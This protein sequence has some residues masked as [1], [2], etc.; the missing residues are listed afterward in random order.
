MSRA[1]E[2]QRMISILNNDDNPSF[3]VRPSKSYKVRQEPTAYS[4]QPQSWSGSG[5]D[6]P[7]SASLRQ[8]DTRLHWRDMESSPESHLYSHKTPSYY[9]SSPPHHG[10]PQHPSRGYEQAERR[11]AA[12]SIQSD[13]RVREQ[14]KLSPQSSF[15]NSA[16]CTAP[17]MAKKNKHACP[18]ATS[19]GCTAT[20]TTSGH[21]ARHG[22]KHTGEK[23][24]HCPVC[25][26]AFTRKDNMKQHRRTHRE[27]G[28]DTDIDS[29]DQSLPDASYSGSPG[30]TTA[31][32]SGYDMDAPMDPRYTQSRRHS[33]RSVTSYE[34]SPRYAYTELPDPLDQDYERRPRSSAY[35]SDTAGRFL[36]FLY[37]TATAQPYVTGGDIYKSLL[38]ASRD[39]LTSVVLYPIISLSFAQLWLPTTT[40]TIRTTG[41]RRDTTT[42]LTRG[43]NCTKKTFATAIRLTIINPDRLR[44]TRMVNR[45]Q[46]EANAQDQGGPIQPK[47]EAD[48]VDGIDMANMIPLEMTSRATV[49]NIAALEA[50]GF[51]AGADE[52]RKHDDRSHRRRHEYEYDDDPRDRRDYDRRRYDYDDRRRD[53]SRG[54]HRRHR[55]T[56][57][58]SRSRNYKDPSNKSLQNTITAALTAG[59]LEAYRA[60]NEPGEW[61]GE[62]GKR[63]LAAVASAGGTEKLLDHGGSGK[64]S[65][66]HI[67]E[68][69]LAGLASGHLAGKS[70]SGRHRSH[71]EGRSKVSTGAT[72]ALLAAAGKKAYEHYQAKSRD[73]GRGG[74]SSDDERP[75]RPGRSNKK[76]SKSV[77]EYVTQGIASLGLNN[78][79]NRDRDRDSGRDSGRDHRR[80]RTR[81]SSPSDDDYDYS[82]RPR[83][84]RRH[85]RY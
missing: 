31:Q 27:S 8:G 11:S 21:A 76:R 6:T 19:H 72:A 77:S 9:S 38:D 35:R 1:P 44:E 59:V 15:S 54:N 53:S 70:G 61:T 69:T 12:H 16:D 28:A 47:E 7:E 30:S 18:Y 65:K 81:Y 42:G 79:H 56:S 2:K 73:S 41:A 75:S 24:V 43:K 34:A 80:H 49:A 40:R 48:I 22:K 68:A 29:Q 66:K 71:S 64:S 14:E 50:L 78:D 23:R 10:V 82:D 84:S 58:D 45:D 13:R 63:I 3:A 60:R 74:Y 57:S 51:T 55:S 37:I 46:E 52:T 36:L 5:R 17:P 62:K 20:F 85:D 26:K 33:S 25:N 39:E 32:L 67:L 4:Q 83:R